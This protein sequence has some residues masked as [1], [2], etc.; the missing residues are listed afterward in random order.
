MILFV[1]FP[2]CGPPP[3][4][5]FAAVTQF[6][7]R[8]VPEAAFLESIGQEITFIL[9]YSGARDGTFAT[10]FHKLDLALAHLGLTSYGISD[11]TLE[12]VKGLW[13]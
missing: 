5:E 3:K 12:E 9:P 8:Y 2:T 10:L 4:G 1:F 6:V 7:C 13:H 11:T